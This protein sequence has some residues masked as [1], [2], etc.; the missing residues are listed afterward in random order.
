MRSRGR[1]AP[2]KEHLEQVPEALVLGAAER[3]AADL[4]ASENQPAEAPEITEVA[5]Y[6]V[7]D[8]HEHESPAEGHGARLGQP[9]LDAAR[10]LVSQIGAHLQVVT[11]AANKGPALAKSVVNAQFELDAADVT[12]AFNL[13]G[14][15]REE[16]AVAPCSIAWL[17]RRSGRRNTPSHS[18]TST[19]KSSRSPGSW[20]PATSCVS[21]ARENTCDASLRHRSFKNVAKEEATLAQ[22]LSQ[23]SSL[24]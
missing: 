7:K 3:E 4:I 22:D 10:E 2:S 15:Q 23:P 11:D 14:A 8:V 9:S 18:A 24:S 17:R 13:A 5:A 12:S 19:R 1:S 16:L 20:P 21:P 6:I